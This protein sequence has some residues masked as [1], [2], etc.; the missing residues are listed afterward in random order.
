MGGYQCPVSNSTKPE[1]DVTEEAVGGW[2]GFLVNVGKPY[3]FGFELLV[4]MKKIRSPQRRKTQESL[5]LRTFHIGSTA[6]IGLWA[7]DH[8]LIQSLT[9]VCAQ[10]DTDAVMTT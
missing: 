8:C 5:G 9:H 7:Q 1:Q 2:G 3:M 4:W 6:S 10:N